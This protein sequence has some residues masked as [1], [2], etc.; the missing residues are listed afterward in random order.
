[1]GIL[2]TAS[3]KPLITKP[4]RITDRNETLIDHIWTNNLQN[5]TINKSHIILSDI[6]D[7]LPCITIVQNPDLHIKGYKYIT[8]RQ[9]NDTNRLQFNKEISRIKDVLSF[10]ATNKSESNLETKY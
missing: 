5:T 9:I 6:T 1:M 8:I 2:T 10:Q 7:H 3:F 4:T